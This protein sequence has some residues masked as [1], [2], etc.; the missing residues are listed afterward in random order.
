[1]MRAIIGVA[2]LLAVGVPTVLAS[3]WA[4][5]MQDRVEEVM[6]GPQTVPS[7]LAGA[8]RAVNDWV[9]DAREGRLAVA[10]FDPV[11]ITDE[12]Y[13][14]W[15]R[16]DVTVA[17]VLAPGETAPEGREAQQLWVT[18]RGLALAQADGCPKVLETIATRCSAGRL[19]IRRNEDGTFRVKARLG[20]A[21]IDDPGPVPAQGRGVDLHDERLRLPVQGALRVPV[22]QIDAAERQLLDAAQDACRNLRADTGTCV[23]RSV[24]FGQ[25]GRGE[26]RDI[27]AVVTLSRLVGPGDSREASVAGPGDARQAALDADDATPTPVAEAAAAGGIFA[28]LKGLL[29]GGGSARSGSGEAPRVLQGGAA[30]NTRNTIAVS[31]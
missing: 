27:S 5:G 1:M 13:V 30:R 6:G 24:L 4:L 22:G 9:A 10:L 21:P 31:R 16:G 29:G 2:V 11:T 7:G 12:R 20:F 26:T 17:D 3:L 25:V 8:G 14:A 15:E 28:T 18:A 19:E 23:I